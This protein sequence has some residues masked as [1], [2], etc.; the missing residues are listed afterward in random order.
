M[1]RSYAML[2]CAVLCDIRRFCAVGEMTALRTP[3]LYNPLFITLTAIAIAL[4]SI[5]IVIIIK[6]DA[7][8]GSGECPEL[9]GAKRAKYMECQMAAI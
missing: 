4:Y 9:N 8:T 2:C 6:T 5:N 3:S 7:D 1:L